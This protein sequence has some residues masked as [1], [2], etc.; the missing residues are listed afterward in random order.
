MDTA[1]PVFIQP[2]TSEERR[3]FYGRLAEKNTAPLWE[4]LAKLFPP[5]PRPACIPT[6]WSYDEI[7]PLLLEAGRL[8]TAK[9]A[10]RR[11]LILENPGIRG[12]SQITQS[13]YA[14]IQMILPGEVA[15][16]H[17][18]TA[19]AI[20]FI[21]EGSGAYTA[22]DG[23]RTTMNPGDFILTPSSTF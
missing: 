6:L 16:T 8:I 20:R 4:S 23:E 7:R 5:E 10:T 15:P 18:H 1:A 9:E 19:S 3:E 22:V 17:R 14:G 21:I 13:L 2:E 11:V 12:T